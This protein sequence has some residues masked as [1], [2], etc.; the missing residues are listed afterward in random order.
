MAGVKHTK[1]IAIADDVSASNAGEVLPSDWNAEHTLSDVGSQTSLDAL[2][3]AVSVLS[4]T[5][6]AEHAA[7][8]VRIDNVTG[9]NGSVTSTEV[10]AGDAAVSAQAASALS[11]ALSVLSVN[12]AGLSVRIDTQSDKISILSQQHSVLSQ[13]HSALSQAVSVLS[14][15]V[16]NEASVRTSADNALS[17]R[18]DTQSQAISVI[19]QQVSALSQAHSVLSQAHSVLSNTNSAEHAALSVRI[20]TQSQAVSVLSQQVSVLSQAHSALSQAHSVLSNVVSDIKSA[21]SNVSCTSAGGGSA[22]GLQAVVDALSNKISTIVAGAASVTSNEFSALSSKLSNISCRAFSAAGSANT[23]VKGLQSVI[24]RI[25]NTFSN[26][27]SAGSV[28]SSDLASVKSV[29]SVKAPWNQAVYMVISDTQSTTAS[30]LTDVSG[31][32]LTVGAN[33][34]W[35]FQGAIVIQQSAANTGLR[36]GFSVPPLSTPRF[37]IFD[38][39][40]AAGQASAAGNGAALGQL[41]VSGNS[42]IL[43]LTST[44]IAAAQIPVRFEGLLNTTSSGTVRLMAA[45]VN[46]TTAS[47]LN[48]LG[49]YMMAFRLK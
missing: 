14:N 34:T 20:D 46:S 28:I 1:T 23:S 11:Q 2:S 13:A 3:N 5:N 24:D 49:G 18:I 26:S 4:N 29:V 42:I 9:G 12:D 43:S 48:I 6:S 37:A 38:C 15:V 10:S 39:I 22:T 27:F 40:S 44:P 25:S 32:V 17:V 33:E 35:R 47:S 36:M 45:G 8:S 7:L 19:S 31:I 21:V 16:S 30:A 41:Q